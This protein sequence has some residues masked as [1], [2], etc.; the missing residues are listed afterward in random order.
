MRIVWFV[1]V[2]TVVAAVVAVS[3]AG[4]ATTT[5]TGTITGQIIDGNV[6]V[7]AEATCELLG[8]QV[9]GSVTVLQGGS[10]L[11]MFTTC[12]PNV[13]GCLVG[14]RVSGNVV[15][16]GARAV[17]IAFTVVEGNLVVS[18]SGGVGLDR[19]SI[20]GTATLTGNGSVLFHDAI[21][22]GNLVCTNNGS[23]RGTFAAS[24]GGQALG[25]CADANER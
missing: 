19:S 15:A 3:P 1:L 17:T 12:S 5:C 22:G 4:A 21:I 20:D 18:N 24:V 6:I 11:L 9:N 25:Q 14:S 16:T 10:L 13:P 7:P 23:V 8:S 2:A